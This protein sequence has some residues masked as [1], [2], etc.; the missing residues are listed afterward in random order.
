[1]S[2]VP[3]RFPPIEEDQLSAVLAGHVVLVFNPPDRPGIWLVYEDGRMA[4]FYIHENELAVQ[5]SKM[6]PPC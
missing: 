6:S 5:L 4:R 1:M 2:E 3:D